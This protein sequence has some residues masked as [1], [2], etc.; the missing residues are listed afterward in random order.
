MRGWFGQKVE[1]NF[2]SKLDW[3]WVSV[4][5]VYEPFAFEEVGGGFRN[6]FR[7]LGVSDLIF[8]VVFYS[9]YVK[10]ILF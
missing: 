9:Y 3:F 1:D 10:L 5:M 4:E 8:V 2:A 7:K 6:G